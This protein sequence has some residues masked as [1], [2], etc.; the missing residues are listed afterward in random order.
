MLTQVLTRV[1][2]V[3]ALALVFSLAVFIGRDRLASLRTEWRPRLRQSAPAFALLLVILGLNRIMRQDGYDIS[4]AYGVHMTEVFYSLEGD[5]VLLFRSIATPEVTT[6]FSVSYVYVYAFVLV[7]PVVAYFALS[8]TVVLRQLLTAYSLNY[9]IGLTFYLLVIAYG[10]R[11]VM[12]EGMDATHLYY[13]NPEYI[14]L[15]TEVNQNRNVFPSLHTSLSAT[16]AIFAYMTRDQYRAWFPVAVGLA[17]SVIIS[18]MYLGIHWA[19]DVV[20]GLVLAAVC[21]VLA[22][23]LVGRWSLSALLKRVQ[24]AGQSTAASGPNRE[25]GD[26][27]A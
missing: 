6:F 25:Q 24:A 8:N 12:I 1:A 2:L 22:T 17:T 9:V 10:P 3:V 27:G 13:A 7:F 11:N 21:V 26:D 19:I 15:T 14:H 5:F 18:T 16:V 23:Q 20:A 4:Q